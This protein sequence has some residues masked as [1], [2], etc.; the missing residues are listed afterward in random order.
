M[1]SKALLKVSVPRMMALA[2]CLMIYAVLG[3]AETQNIDG[4][5]AERNAATGEKPQAGEAAPSNPASL[6]AEKISG[7]TRSPASILLSGVGPLGAV[8]ALAVLILVGLR[9]LVNSR[10]QGQCRGLK[11]ASGKPRMRV[12]ERLWLDRA[13]ELCM[14]ELNGVESLF[15]LCAKGARFLGEISPDGGLYKTAGRPRQS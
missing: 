14:V 10:F 13:T 3:S 2:S 7:R 6:P 12:V 5:V 1:R 4:A 9:P 8:C 15:S 11:A